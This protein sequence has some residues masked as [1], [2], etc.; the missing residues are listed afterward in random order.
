MVIAVVTV[1][2]VQ[3]SV[4]EIINVVAVGN[5]FVS[6]VRSVDMSCFVSVIGAVATAIAVTGFTS[7][8]RR[9]AASLCRIA[10]RR[11]G[12]IDF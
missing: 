5:G 12:F 3:A 11:I 4:D 8:I 10:N 9:T 6:A 2:V 1:R 7:A